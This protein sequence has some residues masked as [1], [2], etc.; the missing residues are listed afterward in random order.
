MRGLGPAVLHPRARAHWEGPTEGGMCGPGRQQAMKV[1][2]PSQWPPSQTLGD[3]SD[4]LGHLGPS[5]DGGWGGRQCGPQSL[6]LHSQLALKADLGRRQQ[7]SVF[8]GGWTGARGA[9]SQ[10]VWEGDNLFF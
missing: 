10:I 6:P 3:T 8:V 7:G 2:E 5:S 9:S 4:P 1:T